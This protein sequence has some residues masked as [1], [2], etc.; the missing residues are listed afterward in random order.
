MKAAEFKNDIRKAAQDFRQ[1]TGAQL[2]LLLAAGALLVLVLPLLLTGLLAGSLENKEKK[3]FKAHAETIIDLVLYKQGWKDKDSKQLEKRTESLSRKPGFMYFM[4]QDSKGKTLFSRLLSGQRPYEFQL[5]E[6]AGIKEGRLN[7]VSS[8]HGTDYEVVEYIKPIGKDPETG[9]IQAWAR[10]G[11]DADQVLSASGKVGKLGYPL[12]VAGMIFMLAAFLWTRYHLLRPIEDLH[13]DLEKARDKENP[14]TLDR[15]YTG[16]ISMLA[17]SMD[18]ILAESRKQVESSHEVVE[19]LEQTVEL[20]S[21]TVDEIYGISSQQST[22]ATEQAASVYQASSTSKEIAASA[23]KIATTA[24]NVSENARQAREASDR[25]KEELSTALEQV[26]EVSSKVEQV[27]GQIVSLGEQSQKITGI[28]DLIR[29]ISEHTN[30]LAL[31]AGIEA[32]GAGEDGKR[33]QVVAQEI[34]R[35]ANRTLD[36]SQVVVELIEKIQTSTNSTVMVTEETMKS[37]KQAEKIMDNMN[38]SFQNILTMVDGTMKASTEISLSTRQQ[39]TACEQMVGT[40]TEVADVASE[41]EKGAKETEES[42]TKINDLAKTL[43]ELAHMTAGKEK[44][45]PAD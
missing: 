31:N 14:D 28:I 22:G 38:Q 30:L 3:D 34:R 40:V 18:R 24:E 44:K 6:P 10:L 33:F 29:E 32:A 16:R 21:E 9:R 2:A 35:L 41:V 37:A 11:F 43:K 36:S 13:A 26:R 23:E 12:A 45:A 20:L 7:N 4:L 5:S 39:T 8:L 17:R 27:A 42:L 19:N 15:G 25:G 1:K